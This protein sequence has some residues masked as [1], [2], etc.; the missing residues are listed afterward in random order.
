MIKVKLSG[1]I[2]NQLFQY[3]EGARKS[4]ENKELLILDFGNIFLG[5]SNH[6]SFINSFHLPVPAECI[7]TNP[8]SALIWFRKVVLSL[9]YRISKITLSSNRNHEHETLLNQTYKNVDFVVSHMNVG[10][11]LRN[12]SSWYSSLSSEIERSPIIAIHI[13]RGDYLL[14]RNRDSIGVLDTAYFQDC[15]R[16]AYDEV[17]A[18]PIWVFSDSTEVQ[19]EFEHVFPARTKYVQAPCGTDP[20]ESIVLMSLARVLIISNSTFSWWSACLSKKST[21]VYG[22]LTWFRNLDQ[23][24]ELLIG[25]WKLV[26]SRWKIDDVQ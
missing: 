10:L 3:F 26:E 23:P 24:N 7:N 2:G 14:P 11:E 16:R 1:G 4:I 19:A 20:A 25:S 17:G 6:A 15:V 5:K 12:P 8:N 13:R 18:L 21:T 22:P 9:R